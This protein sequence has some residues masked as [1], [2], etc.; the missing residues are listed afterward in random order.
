MFMICYTI[1]MNND[2]TM[3][4]RK[5]KAFSMKP[6][7]I[8]SS[9][10][11]ACVIAVVAVII[12]KN[13]KP[14]LEETGGHYEYNYHKVNGFSDMLNLYN[15]LPDEMTEDYFYMILDKSGLSRDDV[16]IND[17]SGECYVS[18]TGIDPNTDFSNQNTEFI[19]FRFTPGDEEST[20]PKIDNVEFHSYRNGKH[21]FILKSSEDEYTH[22]SEGIT[23]TY[24]NK[25]FAI[26]SYLMTL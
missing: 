3:A 9:I 17:D 15:N 13:S 21:D 26:D 5:T 14:T 11:I 4:T 18:T 22:F 23:N 7:I 20:V 2:G 12:V 25:S 1:G 19:S 8:F 24:K 10:A 6:I 16:Q